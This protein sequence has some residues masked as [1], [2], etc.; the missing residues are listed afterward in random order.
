MRGKIIT[1]NSADSIKQA[2]AVNRGKILDVGESEMI[3]KYIGRE[4]MSKYTVNFDHVDWITLPGRL[5]KVLSK[6]L[7][8][9]KITLGIC[10]VPPHSTM[11]PHSHW[12]EELIFAQ[13][14]SNY[15]FCQRHSDFL[16]AV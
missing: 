2:V 8:V 4:I 10:E 12:Q 7:P 1:M 3:S 11:N 15:E 16:K 13:L 6:S 9:K 5:V 14:E